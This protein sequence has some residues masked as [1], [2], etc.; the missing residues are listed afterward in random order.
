MELK[1]ASLIG[2]SARLVVR[3]TPSGRLNA[4]GLVGATLLVRES[5]KKVDQDV[6]NQDQP[7]S[8]MRVPVPISLLRDGSRLTHSRL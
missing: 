6:L 2:F 4:D 5:L 8:Q 7:N 3:A 1:G